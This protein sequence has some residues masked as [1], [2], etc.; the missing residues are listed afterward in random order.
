MGRD[1]APPGPSH[2]TTAVLRGQWSPTHGVT[3]RTGLTRRASAPRSARSLG[4]L[5]ASVVGRDGVARDRPGSGGIAPG[6]S[7][8]VPV[9][10]DGSGRNSHLARGSTS[11]R[12]TRRTGFSE[13]TIEMPM[14]NRI[15]A[16][17]T[18]NGWSP[19]SIPVSRNGNRTKVCSR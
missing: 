13:S 8:I 6:G 9:A 2:V 14:Q 1:R 16:G 17:S 4:R 18:Q 10:V 5:G 19:A 7:T 11:G 15:I 3:R 12:N